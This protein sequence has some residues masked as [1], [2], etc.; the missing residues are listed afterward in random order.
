M[1]VIPVPVVFGPSGA[2]NVRLS[3]ATVAIIFAETGEQYMFP[4]ES[5]DL[6]KYVTS[7]KWFASVSSDGT[8]LYEI[9]PLDGTFLFLFAGFKSGQ[10]GVPS[11]I[12]VK[13]E[14]PEVKYKQHL[15]KFTAQLEVVEGPYKGVKYPYGMR[16]LNLLN[17]SGFGSEDGSLT[18]QGNIQKSPHIAK[19]AQFMELYGGNGIE[20]AYSSNVLP[21]LQAAL[22]RLKN[23]AEGVVAKGWID[24]LQV[25]SAKPK[26]KK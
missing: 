19:L 20:I 26:H 13:K 7:G 14:P 10:D 15:L 22:F 23:L 21:E 4:R 5:V 24:K 12:P 6:P 8:K 18:I 1:K 11:P 2:A 16:Y 17:N 25:Y 3:K 9:R